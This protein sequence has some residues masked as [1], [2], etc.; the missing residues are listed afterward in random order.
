MSLKNANQWLL[1]YY[2]KTLSGADM[3]IFSF[4]NSGRVI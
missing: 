3:E 1:I 4:Y 2:G